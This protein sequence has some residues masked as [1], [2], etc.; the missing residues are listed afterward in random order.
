[1]GKAL[2]LTI[3]EIGSKTFKGAT[4]KTFQVNKTDG[5]TMITPEELRSIV[6]NM[7]KDAKKSKK[8]IK[9][10]VRGLNGMQRFTLKGYNTDLDLNNEDE[11]FD[12][13]VN[14]GTKFA[15]FYQVQITVLKEL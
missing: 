3:K 10:M 4:E 11:Y 7:E 1:M 6:E 14:D 5:K 15:N 2:K 13:K 12:G 8:A 9:F